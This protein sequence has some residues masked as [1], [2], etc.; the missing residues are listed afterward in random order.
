MASPSSSDVE[1]NISDDPWKGLEL[2]SDKSSNEGETFSLH[3]M[4]DVEEMEVDVTALHKEEVCVLLPAL[5]P[6]M[7]PALSPVMSPSPT[8]VMSPLPAEPMLP[9]QSATLSPLPSS[10]M[11]DMESGDNLSVSGIKS[12]AEEGGDMLPASSTLKLMAWAAKHSICNSACNEL[13]GIIEEFDVNKQKKLAKCKYY[14]LIFPILGGTMNWGNFGW[15][16]GNFD[17]VFFLLE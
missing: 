2:S 5:H 10:S 14:F 7:L 3:A 8:L 9:A 16:G 11:S 4:D 15:G 13:L 12:E 1:F 6:E 17:F